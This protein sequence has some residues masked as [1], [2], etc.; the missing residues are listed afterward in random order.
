M[1]TIT[2]EQYNK[3]NNQNKKCYHCC[4]ICSVSYT[5]HK[6]ACNNYVCLDC[7]KSYFKVK[8]DSENRKTVKFICPT[9][10]HKFSLSYILYL[11]SF[12]NE[13]LDLYMIKYKYKYNDV[14]S[15]YTYLLQKHYNI[16]IYMQFFNN[17]YNNK[18][19]N[20]DKALYKKKLEYLQKIYYSNTSID[21]QKLTV[22]LSN[23]SEVLNK[24]YD[25]KLID[26]IISSIYSHDINYIINLSSSKLIS[27]I[28]IDN[29]I[30]NL[31]IKPNDL[32]N[33]HIFNNSNNIIFCKND[34][35]NGGI[36]ENYG[37]KE[38]PEFKCNKCNTLHCCQCFKVLKPNHNCDILSDHFLKNME[39][40]DHVT[41]CPKCNTANVR[42]K[43]CNDFVCA[44]CG[45]F[46]RWDT[47]TIQTATTN[48]MY[49]EGLLNYI[50]E[51]NYSL[52]NNIKPIEYP[53]REIVKN[54]QR[55]DHPLID[56][57]CYQ[58]LTTQICHKILKSL[59]IPEVNNFYKIS[60]IF[61]H[62]PLLYSHTIISSQI[63][64]E[65]IEN[66]LTNSN[67]EQL[68]K[69]LQEIYK[70]YLLENEYNKL[71]NN[72]IIILQS[73]FIEILI[74]LKYIKEIQ[75][76]ANKYTN[77]E[78]KQKFSFEL[79]SISKD[80]DIKIK[81]EKFIR[82]LNNDMIKES[83]IVFTD[84]CN[85]YINYINN[86]ILEYQE[87]FNFYDKYCKKIL[88][89]DDYRMYLIENN[90]ESNPIFLNNIDI[91]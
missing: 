49:N 80:N 7:I 37:T 65:I 11:S 33:K 15:Y 83:N 31:D 43:G 60:Y 63:L 57:N 24:D 89:T 28:T 61:E 54:M 32:L 86:F 72:F 78:L 51:K 36:V 74:H 55:Y 90:N 53:N 58:K 40:P 50:K 56:L 48:E 77:K 27:I 82:K 18:I 44:Y 1:N 13:I 85:K 12:D 10:R 38:N 87:N 52:L 22:F 68:N 21:K 41:H 79:Y 59:D 26:Q 23:L 70:K 75:K 71:V 67:E 81:N 17:Y 3:L 8:L 64:Y 2:E 19:Y 34:E 69:N 29:I 42:I 4:D 20:N 66:K 5:Q 35:C 84:L 46:Y 16:N 39:G 45:I 30:K 73:H 62:V 47:L 76:N 25:N 14:I 6:C 88:F 91:L 9:K